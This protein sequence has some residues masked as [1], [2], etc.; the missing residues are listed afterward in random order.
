MSK[1]ARLPAGA[2]ASLR[3]FVAC[4]L[5]TTTLDLTDLGWIPRPA[6]VPDALAPSVSIGDDATSTSATIKVGYGPFIA[7]ALPA[8]IVEGELRIDAADLPFGIGPNV[9][10]WVDA[11]NATLRANGKRLDEFSVDSDSISLTKK[12][13]VTATDGSTVAPSASTTTVVAAPPATEPPKKSGSGCL[14]WAAG[15]VAAIAVAVGIGVVATNSGD[16]T[17]QTSDSIIV[18]DE[19]ASTEP[20][21]TGPATTGPATTGPA[22]TIAQVGQSDGL[23]LIDNMALCHAF[24]DSDSDSPDQRG[25]D[26]GRISLPSGPCEPVVAGTHTPPCPAT[27][28]V[29][30]VPGAPPFV[31]GGTFGTDHTRQITDAATG[32]LSNSTAEQMLFLIDESGLGDSAANV[33][34]DCNGQ[35]M[36]G[37]TVLRA[38]AI[39]SADIPLQSYGTCQPAPL[40]F[41]DGPQSGLLVVVSPPGD[42]YTVDDAQPDPGEPD[43]ERYV[44]SSAR[45]SVEPT[46]ADATS[47]IHQTIAGAPVDDRCTWFFDAADV[48]QLV[49]VLDG[50]GT[51]QNLWVFAAATT[52]VD[53]DAAISMTD[54]AIGTTA[55]LVAPPPDAPDDTGAFDALFD[56]T[57]FPCG[58]GYIAYTA[59]SDDEPDMNASG[60]VTVSA[61]L[62]DAV[63]IP[64]DGTD[65]AHVVDFG[66]NGGPTYT[67]RQADVGWGVESSAGT[68]RARALIRGNSIT[69]VVPDDEIS[70]ADLGYV[71]RTEI[72][73]Q[74]AEQ[75]PVAVVGRLTVPA[76][77]ATNPDEQPEPTGPSE[78]PEQPV[79]VVETL[80]EFYANLSASLA[81]GDAGFALDRLDPRVFEAFPESCPAV[82]QT[83]ADPDFGIDLVEAG[84][85]EAWTYEAAGL[86]IS[87]PDAIAVT[88]QLRGRGQTGTPTRSHLTLIDGRY[89]WF[90][91]C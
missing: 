90:T 50:C 65:R 7:V 74:V 37:S 57:V 51:R 40:E 47:I 2:P 38:G 67:M 63:P 68:T 52:P 42:P 49:R 31:I 61:S 34:L 44:R 43:V 11:F 62:L 78:L 45:F 16:D 59:C 13:A 69:L 27:S 86:A 23:S 5:D 46:W 32:I 8:S 10:K 60:L 41:L 39:S 58:F 35:R 77:A 24:S 14:A 25:I 22:T 53:I 81:A 3:Q 89:H 4:T 72:D 56:N 70:V 71:W 64:G 36:V 73:G 6:E 75:P 80:P 82:L 87:I 21:T 19:P 48:G 30:E 33:V 1:P 91:R 83:V 66:S 76:L 29:C 54:T 84:P 79:A 17:A 88:V 15:A 9:T 12:P 28:L 26:Y 85:T 55:T 20:A 18:V